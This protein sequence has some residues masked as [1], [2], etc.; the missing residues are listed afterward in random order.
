MIIDKKELKSIIKEEIEKLLNEESS[1][2]VIQ[3]QSLKDIPLSFD[4]TIP[5]LQNL[6]N[7]GGSP[8]TVN[9]LKPSNEIEFFANINYSFNGGDVSF[10]LSDENQNQ[11]ILK[12][13]LNLHLY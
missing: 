4:P 7:L 13:I 8:Y 11:R 2:Q 1:R 10:I 3:A 9:Y 12:N 5:Y 6:V